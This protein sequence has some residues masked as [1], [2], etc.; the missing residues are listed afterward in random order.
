MSEQ[1][2]C[3]LMEEATVMAL[4]RAVAAIWRYRKG[5]NSNEDACKPN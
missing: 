1:Q 3:E 5:I 4:I 2:S